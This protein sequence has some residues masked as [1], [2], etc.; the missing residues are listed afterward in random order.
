VQVVKRE[1]AK[2]VFLDGEDGQLSG[3]KQI[4]FELN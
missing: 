4:E 2:K 1:Y 3:K